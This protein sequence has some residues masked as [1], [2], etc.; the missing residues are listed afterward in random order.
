MRIQ[1]VILRAVGGELTW[2][3]AAQIIGITDRSM[4]RW[5]K[6]YEEHGYDGL[7]DRRCRRPSPKR[8]PLKDVERILKLY[9]EEYEDF[10]VRHF[11][12]KL[13]EEHEVTL[14]YTFVKA[15]LQTAGLVRKRRKRGRHFRRR[16]PKPC[17]GQMLHIDGSDHAWL[18]LVPAQRDSL[19]VVVDDATSRMLYAQLWPEET[20][21][22]ILTA[23]RTVIAEN[24]IP[25][26]LY[27][28]RAS[29]AF[30]T[31]E[32]GSKVCKTQL[33][34]VGRALDRLGIEHIA[35][36]SPQA[37]GRSERVNRTLQDR[38]VNELKR[39]GIVNRED[40]N[41]YINEVYLPDHNQRFG[42][43]AADPASCFVS[44]G[45]TVLDDILCVEEVRTVSADNV[46]RYANRHLQIEKQADRP[47]CKGLEVKV[48]HHLDGTY[49]VVRGV[50][51]LGRYDS[52]GC[53][54]PTTHQR[55]KPAKA[56][57][58]TRATP[59]VAA[60]SKRSLTHKT[61]PKTARAAQAKRAARTKAQPRRSK[62][63]A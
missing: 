4:R 62:K 36:Y 21:E 39:A 52:S 28:D 32:A 6:R 38:L 37:R 19:I 54:L 43:E 9:R 58:A 27:N 56:T 8:V 51:T 12:E 50:R 60:G 63:A 49:S 13:Q 15:A 3:Q 20:T 42:R 7:V 29:W 45:S 23:L 31:A 2:I 35:A 55:P 59:T 24:G 25:M 18:A 5:R 48:R 61:A 30:Y 53:A 16:E 46:V 40:A 41:R 47:T 10:N 11:H 44:A 1:E 33:T 57:S 34:Q 17:V 14:S 26:A 22:A